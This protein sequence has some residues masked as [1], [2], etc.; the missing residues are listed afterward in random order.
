MKASDQGI[1][2]QRYAVI[3]RTLIFLQCQGRVLLLKGGAHKRLWAGKYNGIGGHVEPGE[4]VHAAAL[5]ELHE[6]SG[7]Q[8]S[9]LQLAGIIAIDGEPV[10]APDQQRTGIM[11]FVFTGELDDFES[12][13]LSNEGKTAW[14]E[15]DRLADYPLVEDIPLIL[16]GALNI[17][18]GNIPF[19]AN[20]S[21][22]AEGQ[23]QFKFSKGG[24]TWPN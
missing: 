2:L 23:I 8:L 21:V 20:Y 17:N 3:P 4:D 16:E 13:W 10:T 6:E 14:L 5:R 22:D 15:I 24:E 11:I 12:G 7:I 19:Y 18:P 9:A 1:T